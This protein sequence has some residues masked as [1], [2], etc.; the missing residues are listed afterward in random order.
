MEDLVILTLALGFLF[1]P[2]ISIGSAAE[3]PDLNPDLG[4]PAIL[5]LVGSMGGS[6]GSDLRFS[7]ACQLDEVVHAS[8]NLRVMAVFV[9]RNEERRFNVEQLLM[10]CALRTSSAVST[11]PCHL[12]LASP[13]SI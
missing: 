3:L 1:Q 7:H 9:S 10:P 2:N 6:L 11:A 13:L 8:A 4:L 5:T 12:S